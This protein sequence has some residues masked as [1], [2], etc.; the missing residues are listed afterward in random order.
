MRAQLALACGF[1]GLV[2]GCGSNS[3]PPTVAPSPT[4]SIEQQTPPTQVAVTT[5]T[6]LPPTQPP[7][8]VDPYELDPTKHKIPELPVTG[9]LSGGLFTPVVTVHGAELSFRMV[10][11]NKPDVSIAFE[12]PLPTGVALDGFKL[13][14]KPD[15]DA[16]PTFPQLQI[17]RIAPDQTVKRQGY[18]NGYAITLEFGKRD[19][20]KL[21]GRIYLCLPDETKSYIAGTFQA[22]V[23]RGPDELPA[24]DEAPFVR[25]KITIVGLAQGQLEAG[26]VGMPGDQ[27]AV[28][29]VSLEIGA[30]GARLVR[31]ESNLPRAT[32]VIVTSTGELRYDH[33]R[34][35]PGRYL[36]YAKLINGPSVWKWVDVTANGQHDNPLTLDPAQLG[37]VEVKLPAEVTD[38]VQLIPLDDSAK[39]ATIP[40]VTLSFSLRYE[41]MPAKGLAKLAKIAAGK[42]RVI[43]GTRNGTVEV[44]PGMTAAVDL[45]ASK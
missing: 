20:G 27:S 18:A 34:L 14:V 45:N 10:T 9:K 28:D 25:G 22:D 1:L 38:L 12:V 32:S 21:P 36:L 44:K 35:V 8:P 42:Y 26:Y 5:P 3:A 11:P 13:V 24:S 39:P 7:A 15:Q 19:K 33:V 2:V 31:S 23:Q 17:D 41:A 29:S 4:P 37:S 16:G 43:A 40:D 6:P 30:A